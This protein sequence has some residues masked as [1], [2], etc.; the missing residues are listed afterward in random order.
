[1]KKK[2]IIG[3][4]YEQDT[5][6]DAIKSREPEF[7]AVYGRRRVGKTFLIK[8]F[9]KE[10]IV[11]EITGIH[12]ASM[13]DQLENFAISLGRAAGV[14]FKPQRPL[15]W[16]DAFQQL[17]RFYESPFIN[18]KKRK[19]VIFFDELPWLNT[20]RSKF[21]S[22][23]EH[24]WNSW[25]ANRDDLILVVCGSAASWMIQNIVTSKGGLH[26]R[27]TKQ[28]R[29]LPFTLS[30][31]E[32]FLKSRNVKL[33]RFQIID[34]YMTMGGIPHYLKQIE[35]GLS[36]SQIIE[37]ICFLSGGFLRH[38]FNKLYSSLFDKSR[39]YVNIIKILAKKRKGLTR[40][41][42]LESLGVSSGGTISARLQELEESGFIQSRIPFGKKSNEAL[43]WLTDEYSLFYIDWIS[44]LKNNDSGKGYWQAR[45]N[46]PKK[47]AW[48]GYAFER[49][50]IKHTD[51][52]KEALGILNVETS[53]APW[54]GRYL[55]DD[56]S[57]IG[58]QIDL[59]ID[60]KDQTINICEMKF[61][62]SE[63]VIDKKYANSLRQKVNVLKKVT[64]TKKNILL[65]M[66][67]TFGVKDNNYYKELVQNTV[68]LDDL[69]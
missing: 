47:R 67:T 16:F 8:E 37:D 64:G 19:K 40:N 50:C 52:I 6:S 62:E 4:E 26:N 25:G 35:P 33:S 63:F 41:E 56:K 48:A 32:L 68:V 34:L 36:S 58:A 13:N 30:E 60:R 11:F 10:L 39:Q 3:R 55:G 54:Q 21:L 2:R 61:S 65:T 43:Y 31:T 9:F 14:G 49:I 18:K 12:K 57:S 7:I 24:F 27:L 45:L 59:L 38:E 5:L 22:A 29:L 46:S 66:I 69:F 42:I 17:I 23:L 53:E 15:S 44:K 20:P 28:I 1:M 51:K